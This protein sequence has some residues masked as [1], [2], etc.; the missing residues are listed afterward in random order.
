MLLESWDRFRKAVWLFL[1]GASRVLQAAFQSSKE[2]GL[3][4]VR[5]ESRRVKRGRTVRQAFLPLLVPATCIRE[6]RRGRRFA[7][8]REDTQS[9]RC[10]SPSR[11]HGHS[12]PA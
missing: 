6:C 4:P 3:S 11:K 1:G 8:C 7:S 12:R 2:T 5:K 10:Q 9:V